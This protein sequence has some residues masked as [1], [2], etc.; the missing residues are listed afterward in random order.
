M[1]PGHR[2]HS[3]NMI[4]LKTLLEGYVPQLKKYQRV[5]VLSKLGNIF[6]RAIDVDPSQWP[7]PGQTYDISGIDVR[8]NMYGFT[9]YEDGEVRWHD[10]KWID[11]QMKKGKIKVV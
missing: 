6:S 7:Q 8:G 1:V 10:T 9:S 4:K 5:K 11:D 3:L 2:V